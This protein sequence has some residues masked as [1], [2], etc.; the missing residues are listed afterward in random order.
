MNWQPLPTPNPNKFSL[1]VWA[2]AKQVVQK[3]HTME[4]GGTLLKHFGLATGL[5]TSERLG[6]YTY[7]YASGPD[8][9]GRL[10]FHF[11]EALSAAAKRVP[12]R[13]MDDSFG[14]HSWPAI[15]KAMALAEDS[16]L[17]L[18]A[19]VIVGADQGIAIGPRYYLREEFIPDVAEG[20]RFVLY[21]FFDATPFTVRRTSVPIPTRVAFQTPSLSAQFQ[22]ALHDEIVIPATRTGTSQNAG[23]TTTA[24]GGSLDEQVF[25]ATNFRRWRPY[26][27]KQGQAERDGGYYFYMLRVFPPRVPRS[28][29]RNA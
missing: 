2:D 16:T 5:P 1:R 9:Q 20:S 28:I 4:A 11:T 25:P 13:V 19:N 24:V 23:G 15:I 18:S 12:Y 10:A 26:F 3:M 7:T 27:C 22:E 21:Q 6:S 17:P 14:N 8:E 29:I